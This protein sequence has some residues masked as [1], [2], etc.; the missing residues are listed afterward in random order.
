MTVCLSCYAADNWLMESRAPTT[1]DLIM[2]NVGLEQN[3]ANK[4]MNGVN[5]FK[6]F[7]VSHI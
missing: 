7:S 1:E 2:M 5:I 6:C 4:G 3:H